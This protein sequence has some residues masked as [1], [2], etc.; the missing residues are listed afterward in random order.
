MSKAAKD[1]KQLAQM[2]GFS[3]DKKTQILYGSKD[4]FSLIISAAGYNDPY[5]LYVVAGAR[6]SMEGLTQNDVWQFV[7][8]NPVTSLDQKHNQV[9]MGLGREKKRDQLYQN[10]QR[11]INSLIGL[12]RQ[13]GF[14]PCCASCGQNV[15][16]SVYSITGS[17][18]TDAYAAFCPACINRAQI[19]MAYEKN[20][21]RENVALGIVGALVGSLIGAFLIVL[22]AQLGWVSVLLGF[23]MAVCTFKGYSLLGGKMTKKGMVICTLIV[24]FMTYVSNNMYWAILAAVQYDIN[25][26]AA[27]G[28]VP[29]LLKEGLIEASTYNHNLF[30]ISVCTVAGVAVEFWS[31]LKEGKIRKI[32][33]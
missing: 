4:G 9:L 8:E 33:P 31:V 16:T 21:K 11:S 12:L 28:I 20:R 27:F 7:N 3:F 18:L 2:L 17:H 10:L 13:K 25:I 22:L 6:P 1:Y 30:Y 19:N 32:G 14:E 26:F 24:L 15:E 29:D 23:A 5:R